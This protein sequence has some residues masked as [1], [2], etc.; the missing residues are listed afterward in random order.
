MSAQFGIFF[1]GRTPE[2]L[3]QGGLYSDL[4]L[5]LY[6]GA[7]WPVSVALVAKAMGAKEMRSGFQTASAT[8]SQPPPVAEVAQH[9]ESVFSVSVGSVG[10]FLPYTAESD[11]VVSGRQTSKA[12]PRR[13]CS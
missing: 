8:R 4:A 7:F 10:T 6:S 9:A 2:D 11:V 13:R 5:A 1:D 12:K 3:K